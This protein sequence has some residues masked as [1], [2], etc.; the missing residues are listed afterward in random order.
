MVSGEPSGQ[1]GEE[2]VHGRVLGASGGVDGGGRLLRIRQTLQKV[3]AAVEQSA[4][5]GAPGADGEWSVSREREVPV[6]GG[7]QAPQDSSRWWRPGPRQMVSGRQVGGA[8]GAHGKAGGGSE[9]ECRR[10]AA[11]GGINGQQGTLAAAQAA[12]DGGSQQAVGGGGQRAVSVLGV[13]RLRRDK[14]PADWSGESGR[15]L[16][17]WTESVFVRKRPGVAAD[18]MAARRKD[19][20]NGRVDCWGFL[21]RGNDTSQVVQHRPQA[22]DEIRQVMRMGSGHESDED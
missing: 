18:R 2:R 6:D 10:R 7:Q 9:V 1:P 13:A 16:R 14:R 3:D 19:A 21:E 11:D 17:V 20:A 22:R 4:A 12:S 5:V 15:Q 8:A